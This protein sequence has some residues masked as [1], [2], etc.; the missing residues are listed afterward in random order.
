[1]LLTVRTEQWRVHRLARNVPS[2]QRTPQSTSDS[3]EFTVDKVFLGQLSDRF[4]SLVHNIT[5]PRPT[6][7][8][9]LLV[10][11]GAWFL[12][13]RQAAR[14]PDLSSAA[15]AAAPIGVSAPTAVSARVRVRWLGGWQKRNGF[16]DGL[17]LGACAHFQAAQ[18][19]GSFLARSLTL[20][21]SQKTTV[22]HRRTSIF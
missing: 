2:N 8:G 20:T 22:H 10:G 15:G 17:R 18:D 9:P 6:G 7:R 12:P 11:H 4:S 5:A 1:M 19:R 14:M 3:Y 13:K 21:T 16:P